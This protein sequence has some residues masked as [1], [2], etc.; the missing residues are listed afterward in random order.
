MNPL[1]GSMTPGRR[2]NLAHTIKLSVNGRRAS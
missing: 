1:A 2:I